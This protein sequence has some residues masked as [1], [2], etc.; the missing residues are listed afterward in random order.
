VRRRVV[1]RFHL[2]PNEHSSRRVAALRVVSE[3]A[4][5]D[6]DRRTGQPFPL[7]RDLVLDAPA[8]LRVDPE[9]VLRGLEAHLRHLDRGAVLLGHPRT[10]GQVEYPRLGPVVG[11]R[12][13]DARVE[14]DEV[15]FADAAGVGLVEGARTG[16]R[17]DGRRGA[18]VRA[19]C[20]RA[21]R[22]SEQTDDPDAAVTPHT[23][24]RLRPS[25]A[26]F[27]PG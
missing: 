23:Q 14:V 6:G 19:Q 1:R 17:P 2:E 27:Q 13:G 21:E 20:S 22:G 11:R 3:D 24:G 18:R 10:R 7:Q 25:G 15:Q 9:A 8:R 4:R 5:S 26:L 16:A 12:E